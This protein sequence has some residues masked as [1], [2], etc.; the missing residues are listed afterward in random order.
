VWL[1]SVA[2]ADALSLSTRLALP[3]ADLTLTQ[4][5]HMARPRGPFYKG[6]VL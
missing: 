3:V 4:W 1:E 5:P 2:N 6:S